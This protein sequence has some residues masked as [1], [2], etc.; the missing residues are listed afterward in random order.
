MAMQPRDQTHTGAFVATALNYYSMSMLPKQREKLSEIYSERGPIPYNVYRRQSYRKDVLLA[1]QGSSFRVPRNDG[2]WWFRENGVTPMPANAWTFDSMGSYRANAITDANSRALDKF[3]ERIRGNTDLSIDIAQFSKTA[4][5]G[6]DCAKVIKSLVSFKRNPLKLIR[7][8]SDA[9]LVWMYGVKPTLGSIYDAVKHT[10]QHYNNEF[11]FT[12]AKGGRYFSHEA[13]NY[14]GSWP[15]YTYTNDWFGETSARV[16]IGAIM[17]IPD[18]PQ[19]QLARLSSLNPVS[20]AWELVPFSFVVDWFYD[21]G[22]YL[23]DL[24]TAVTY[25]SY[26]VRGFKTTTTRTKHIVTAHRNISEPPGPYSMIYRGKWEFHK[27]STEKVRAPLSGYPYPEAPRLTSANL[28][29]G[30]LLNAAALLG[31]FLGKGKPR[32]GSDYQRATRGLF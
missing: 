28:G 10:A 18:T 32:R 24:E 30:R 31:T 8:V 23:R 7:A 22:G 11:S 5:L 14:G 3:N 19:T 27:I 9:R 4:R 2:S 29:S 17:R 1:L 15:D 25:N 6:H 16:Q 20:I 21:I 26:F 12:T 13:L